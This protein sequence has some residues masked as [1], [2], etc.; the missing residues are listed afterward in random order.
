MTIY[1]PL[2]V[3]SVTPMFKKSKNG[4][5]TKGKSLT[6]SHSN[7]RRGSQLQ[8]LNSRKLCERWNVHCFAVL[9]PDS[10]QRKA[11]YNF[12][13]NL[14]KAFHC[15]RYDFDHHPISVAC[16]DHSAKLEELH[17]LSP[18]A[19]GLERCISKSNSISFPKDFIIFN[20]L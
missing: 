11:K 19:L 7:H 2:R 18:S 14:E 15:Q 17:R 4:K 20:S 10:W 3:N 13:Q 6:R 5:W 16:L 12:V 1:Y 9:S 8:N